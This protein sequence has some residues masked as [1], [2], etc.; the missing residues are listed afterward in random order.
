MAHRLNSPDVEA[1]QGAELSRLR[2]IDYSQ[3]AALPRSQ[4]TPTPAEIRGVEF[5]I[6]RRPGEHGGVRIEI[7]ACKRFLLIFVSCASP[8][9]EMLPDG[10]IVVEPYE[11]PED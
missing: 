4:R 3:L 5:W 8:G 10:S 1:F 11:Q 7:R 2:A 6:E 9:F